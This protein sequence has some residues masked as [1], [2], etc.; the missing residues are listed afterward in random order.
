MSPELSNPKFKN[1]LNIPKTL[2]KLNKAALIGL[3]LIGLS[4]SPA[5][6]GI[7]NATLDLN[8][9]KTKVEISGDTATIKGRDVQGTI[10]L[11]G[12]KFDITVP[13]SH[14]DK[15][16]TTTITANANLNSQGPNLSV[17]AGYNSPDITLT[18]TA[19]ATPQ[20]TTLNTQI[21]NKI[22]LGNTAK[23][24]TNANIEIR[25]DG[26]A[27]NSVQMKMKTLDEKIGLDI[28]TDNNGTD[29]GLSYNETAKQGMVANLKYSESQSSIQSGVS[30]RA[31]E[32]T[33]FSVESNNGVGANID[34]SFTGSVRT[35]LGDPKINIKADIQTNSYENGARI[36]GSA[37]YNV[38][39]STQVQMTVSNSGE[40]SA[41][42]GYSSV[43][44]KLK[45]LSVEDLKSR[46]DEAISNRQL[47]VQKQYLASKKK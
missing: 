7:K 46:I 23:I 42:I 19:T 1:Q 18:T 29:A 9:Q 34:N 28:F 30:Y 21:Q 8:S 33:E 36:S 43:P 47:D 39:P 35:N 6:A 10:N 25:S 31:S 16:A 41:R 20:N 5:M 4:S 14:S 13:L 17:Q 22:K 11:N 2:P 40:T 24:D 12:N 15:N 27:T 37:T 32:Q 44:N 45:D 26:Q 3:G 38:T